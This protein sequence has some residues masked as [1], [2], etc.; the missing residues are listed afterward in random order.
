MSSTEGARVGALFLV[1]HCALF[2]CPTCFRPVL[3]KRLLL[4]HLGIPSPCQLRK[5]TEAAQKKDD[6]NYFIAIRSCLPP[7]HQ[8]KG[9]EKK[10]PLTTRHTDQRGGK[11]S[12][13]GLPDELASADQDM[14]P[15]R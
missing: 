3:N 11:C 6:K 9:K 10:S 4:V 8:E 12:S 2:V 7:H 5:S 1:S 15:E 13:K 14:G